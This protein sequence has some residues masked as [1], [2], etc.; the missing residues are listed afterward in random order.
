MDAE[1]LNI[2]ADMIA[3]KVKHYLITMIGITV[4][5]ASDEE[6]Y[7]AFSMTLREEIMINWTSTFH[8]VKNAHARVVYYLCMEYMPGKMLG[9]NITNM[10]ASELVQATLKKLGRNLCTLLH[11]EKDPGLGNG[12]LGRLAS[13]FLDSLA[14]QQYPSFAY[15]LR[16]QYGIF[17]QEICDG[18]QVERPEAWLLHENPWEFRRDSHAESVKFA[19]NPIQAVNKKGVPVLDIID[20]EEVRAIA[21]DIPIIGYREGIDFNVSTLRLWTTKESP[22][23]FALQRFNAGLLDQAAENTSLTDVL[24]PNDNNEVGKR[25]RLKQEFLL[26]SASLQDIIH[27]HLARCPDMSSFADKVRIQINDT[28][29]SLAIPELV[30]LLIHDYDFGWHEAWDVVKTCCSFTN[31]TILKESLEEWNENRLQYLLPR[32]YHVIERLNLEFCNSIRQQYPGDE[33][34]VRR[35]SIIEAGQVRMAHLAIY[36]SHKVNGVSALHTEILKKVVF[37]D[38]AEMFQDRFINVTNGVTQRRF[39]LHCNPRLAEF[40]TKRIGPKWITDFSEI[41]HLSKFASDPASQQEFLTIKKLNK[42][43]LM[44]YLAEK[45]PIRDFRGKAIGHFEPLD[46]EAIYDVQIKRIHEYKRQLMNVLHLIMVYHELKGNSSSRK[47]KRM[48]FFAGKAAPGYEMAKRIIELIYC[49]AKKIN[50]DPAVNKMLKVA[51]IE[52]YNVSRAELIIPAA[53]LSEQISTAGTEASGTGNM[54]LTINGALTIGTNDGATVEMRQ[55]VGDAWWPFAFGKSAEENSSLRPGYHPMD[56]YMSQLPIRQA[57]DALRD[58]SFADN[59]EQHE[60]LSAIYHSLLE[61]ANSDVPDR[62]FVLSDLQNYYDTQKKVE[63]LYSQP[64]K[65]AE[66]VLNNIAGMGKF[67][68]DESIHNY[69]KLVWDIKP[70]PIDPKEL[71]RV[72][73]EY[74]EHDKCRILNK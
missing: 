50:A 70:C 44:M 47:V 52:N 21:Y 39:L 23:N 42:K 9:N 32:Q 56:L 68:S 65:W 15:G 13:C 24:Y 28:H 14:T 38:F 36:G 53:D 34:R 30:R 71:S 2:Q 74:S 63:E 25:I 55:A 64:S 45:N 33:E 61:Q 37:K 54:K 69:A 12:G 48:A 72:R 51:F 3:S 58:R 1:L 18:V 66:Y 26:V 11:Q 62:Y 4:D 5:E 27:G 22:R 7:R 67:S 41:Q 40:I 16:Y 17:E 57:L 8:T 59:D 49:V 31:H 29:P 6:F 46:E 35:M 19:G 43:D 73:D 10:H 20:F 60:A